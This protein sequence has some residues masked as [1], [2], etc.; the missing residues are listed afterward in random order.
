MARGH[1]LQAWVAVARG[2]CLEAQD[3]I[4]RAQAV[5]PASEELAQVAQEI[6]IECQAVQEREVRQDQEIFP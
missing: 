4:Q 6:K 2:Q 1:V 3:E 5:D